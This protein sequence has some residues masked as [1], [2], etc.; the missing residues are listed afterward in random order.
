MSTTSWNWIR[1]NVHSANINCCLRES[2]PYTRNQNVPHIYIL[3]ASYTRDGQICKSIQIAKPLNPYLQELPYYILYVKRGKF[4]GHTLP[5]IQDTGMYLHI[6]QL[7]FVG[8]YKSSSSESV[9][10]KWETR[11]MQHDD[12]E[13]LANLKVQSVKVWMDCV[14]YCMSNLGRTTKR[15]NTKCSTKFLKIHLEV[16]WVDLWQLHVL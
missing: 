8:Y 9:N 11:K 5:W 12:T 4:P 13:Q 15:Y 3:D 2:L 10:T 1:W 7:L 6:Q 14:S 16:E